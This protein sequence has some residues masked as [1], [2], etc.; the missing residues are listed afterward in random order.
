[1]SSRENKLLN[2][3]RRLGSGERD[4]LL[5]FAEFLSAR[6]VDDAPTVMEPLS[7]SRPENESVVSAMK[8]LTKTYPMLETK[9]LFTQASSFMT[10]HIMHGR[11]A[12]EI[13]DEL[14]QLFREHYEKITNEDNN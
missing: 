12:M 9:E 4:S 7:I 11:E 2:L 3:F 5:D 8:R 6:H 13:I 14:E 10:Q 1:L